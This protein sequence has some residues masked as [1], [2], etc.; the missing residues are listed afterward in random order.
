MLL[1]LVIAEVV[2]NVCV[3]LCKMFAR[4]NIIIHTVLEH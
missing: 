3:L 4:K 1:I 2:D